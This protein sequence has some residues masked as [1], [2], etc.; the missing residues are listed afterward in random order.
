MKDNDD[1]RLVELTNI[2]DQIKAE[3]IKVALKD[4]GIECIL[5]KSATT[6]VYPFTVDGLAETKIMVNEEDISEAREILK[7]YGW[8]DFQ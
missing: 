6:S 4:R 8:K 2:T 3:M 1:L 7:N 5:Q